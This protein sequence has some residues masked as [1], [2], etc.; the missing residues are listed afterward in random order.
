MNW[1]LKHTIFFILSI[2]CVFCTAQINELDLRMAMNYY[3]NGDFEKAALYFDKLYSKSNLDQIYDPYRRTLIEIQ[4]FKE[5]EKICK[6]QIKAYPKKYNYLVD[7][8]KVLE[9][10][11]KAEKAEALYNQAIQKID[12]NSRHVE[13][14]NLANAFEKEGM[15]DKALI[16]YQ[17]GNKYSSTQ[18]R[19]YNQKIAYIY[20]RQGKTELVIS[21]LL[22]LIEINDA[23]YSVVQRGL[24]NSIDLL[25]DLKGRELL[26]KA[27]VKKSQ[28]NPGKIIYNEM[29][30]WYFSA[31]NDF[32]GSFIQ[33]KAIDKKQKLGG[34][35]LLELGESCYVN[36]EY[37]VA[38]KCYDE[39]IKNYPATSM[40]GD[41][42]SSR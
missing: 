18:K 21:T 38:I 36:E 20:G 41:N 42:Y 28:Q 8:G 26:R 39:I 6:I 35:R 3:N 27:L 16:V 24:S 2:S 12:E 25:S 17:L 5:A 31:I 15:I 22:E 30:A 23:Y 19:I 11:E 40:A 32:E 10:W 7:Q 34:K 1:I 9:F 29:L 13:I 14:S 4:R 37:D 33:V